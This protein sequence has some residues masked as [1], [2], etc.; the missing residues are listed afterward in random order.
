MYAL[1]SYIEAPFIGLL[2]LEVWVARLPFL[3]MGMASL[4][5]FFVLVRDTLDRRTARLGVALLAL[6]PWHIM[7][8]PGPSPPWC[9][10][11]SCLPTSTG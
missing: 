4:P 8:S 11:S 9:S 6:S 5:L 10:P 1:A 7:V 3:L 2:G